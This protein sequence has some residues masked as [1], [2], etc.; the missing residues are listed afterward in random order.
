MTSQKVIKPCNFSADEISYGD[1]RPMGTTGA[2]QCYVNYEGKNE[3]IMLHTPKMR[4]PYGIGK[5]VEEGKPTKYSLDMSFG[6]MD[7]D[8]KI[9]EFYEALNSLDEKI[10]A[11]TK[12]NSLQWL[13]KKSVS[14]DVARTLY[15]PSIKVAK[16][17]ETGEVTDKYPPTFKAKIPCWDDNFTC[18]VWDHER[19]KIEGDFTE[20][21]TKGQSVVAIVKCA[22]VWFA[23][24]KYGVTWQV[25]Q[26]KL[27]KPK[28]ITGYAFVESDDEED[29]DL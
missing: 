28:A 5:Y 21:V 23:S 29:E 17:K 10:I 4:L 1:V 25:D 27:D 22:R 7:D 12:K 8:P 26:L 6:G 9:K 3:A 19:N 2:K 24:G 15:T 18:T 14:E 13:R 20:Q 16:D 11:D